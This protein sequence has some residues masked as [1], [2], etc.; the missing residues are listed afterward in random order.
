MDRPAHGPPDPLPGLRTGPARTRDEHRAEARAEAR[1]Q[2][3]A[4]ARGVAR[5][6]ILAQ[7]TP[8]GSVP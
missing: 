6:M 8:R 2:A 5:S 3:R 1:A 4:Q 7:S